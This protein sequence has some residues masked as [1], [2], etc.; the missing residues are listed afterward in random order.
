MFRSWHIYY[1]PINKRLCHPAK[2]NIV[3]TP[4][5]FWFPSLHIKNITVIL[6]AS[7]T[8]IICKV[9][10]IGLLPS[11]MMS[12]CKNVL[13]R[14]VNSILK[15]RPVN[16]CLCTMCRAGRLP[17]SYEFLCVYNMCLSP[18]WQCLLSYE[19]GFFS[20]LTACHRKVRV[21]VIFSFLFF[22]S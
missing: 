16:F 6:S 11:S 8:L 2:K 19:L 13:I 18:G 14:P 3:V 22:L 1:F 7:K 12:A 21:H 20:C 17:N 4:M 9:W 10:S 15:N 5:H